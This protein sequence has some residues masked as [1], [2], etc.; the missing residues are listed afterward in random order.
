VRSALADGARGLGEVTARITNEAPVEER[1]ATTGRVA[2]TVARVARP[3]AEK[4]RPW[5]ALGNGIEIEDWPL[6]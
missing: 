1:F 6:G 3:E 5:V 4:S 2:E